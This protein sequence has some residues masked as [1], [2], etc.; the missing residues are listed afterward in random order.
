M[1][2]YFQKDVYYGASKAPREF[3][4]DDQRGDVYTDGLLSYLL[5]TL[6]KKFRNCKKLVKFQIQTC[7]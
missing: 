6:A 4:E 7:I 5:V 2:L 3:Y 1:F